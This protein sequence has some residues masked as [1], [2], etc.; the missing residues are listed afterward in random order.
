L[1][2]IIVFGWLT[3]VG[4]VSIVW[5]PSGLGLALVLAKGKKIW[6]GIFLG[7]FASYA[8]LLDRPLWLSAAI[9]LGCNAFQPIVC[10]YG[11][12]WANLSGHRFDLNLR[13][14]LDYVLLGLVG[15]VGAGL[16]ALTGC[17]ILLQANIF[18]VQ[19]LPSSMLRWWMGD[20]LG[21]VV[22]APLFIV[23]RQWPKGWFKRS[24]LAETLA[25]FGLA[26]CINQVLF[27]DWLLDSI[28][29]LARGYWA[30]LFAAWAAVRFERHGA[31]LVVS[32]VAVQALLGALHERGIFAYDMVETGLA[33]FWLYLLALTDKPR[34][35]CAKA[36][37]TSAP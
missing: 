20:F 16:A 7:A 25:C 2:V 10:A 24:R 13:H 30:F 11:L 9:A 5:F 34:R 17:A 15:A 6:P 32:M 8:F 22:A 4:H 19:E 36:K 12:N 23:W 27:E 1:L 3:R 31:L 21:L 26:F 35:I 29:R 33:G 37:S 18:P 28:G 14:P